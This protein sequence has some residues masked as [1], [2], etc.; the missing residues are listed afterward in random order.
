[1]ILYFCRWDIQYVPHS[2]EIKVLELSL[3]GG[4]T[5]GKGESLPPSVSTVLVSQSLPSHFRDQQHQAERSEEHTSEL[6]S[7]G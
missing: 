7:L 3:S 4:S 1:M 5:L 2:A 6:Q